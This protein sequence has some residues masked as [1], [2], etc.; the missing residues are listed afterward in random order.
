RRGRLGGALALGGR[1]RT[2][3][4]A[5]PPLAAGRGQLSGTSG[6]GA[7]EVITSSGGGP[8]LGVIIGRGCTGLGERTD[9]RDR[10]H[11]ARQRQG[12]EPVV[13]G[14]VLGGTGDDRPHAVGTQPVQ[15]R[16]V[17]T[18]VGVQDRHRPQPGDR[19][20][21]QLGHV[22]APAHHPQ[23]R[24]D[25]DRAD[26]LLLRRPPQRQ[27]HPDVLLR[28]HQ[29]GTGTIVIVPSPVCAASTSARSSTGTSTW[30]TIWSAPA[31]I[32]V[33]SCTWATCTDCTNGSGAASAAPAPPP[34]AGSATHR[35]TSPPG[36]MLS[37]SA[38]ST[39]TVTVRTCTLCAEPS[40]A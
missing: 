11:P 9:R 1:I 13:A 5:A 29:D 14:H 24:F 37:A 28:R 6:G 18:Q 2:G 35:S 40:A 26:Q 7:P 10:V 3:T 32:E 17:H 33:S 34:P 19:G 4:L 21:S 39:G 31:K 23:P 20:S 36:L 16:A 22:R 12:A 25:G 8:R 38:A 30:A 27:Q 15:E